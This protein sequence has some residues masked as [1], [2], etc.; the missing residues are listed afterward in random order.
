[1]VKQCLFYIES[2]TK[3]AMAELHHD[4]HC[5]GRPKLPTGNDSSESHN[6]LIAWVRFYVPFDTK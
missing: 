6:W 5:N 1:M 2:L 3:F 4:S